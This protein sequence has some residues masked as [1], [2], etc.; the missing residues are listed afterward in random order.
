MEPDL[1]IENSTLSFV[2]SSSVTSCGKSSS[3]V[4]VTAVPVATLI[5]FRLELVALRESDAVGTRRRLDGAGAAAV[6]AACRQHEDG[7]G[8]ERGGVPHR[9]TP[10]SRRTSAVTAA[11]PRPAFAAHANS[12]TNAS[13]SSTSEMVCAK[14]NVVAFTWYV[15]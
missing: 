12:S 13:P 7:R 2:P 4:H 9:S 1:P 11:R 14:R 6:A 3:L 5:A 10:S 8:R 15:M